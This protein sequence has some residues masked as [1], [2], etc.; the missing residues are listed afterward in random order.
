MYW[1]GH[2][3]PERDFRFSR[4]TALSHAPF[5]R[6]NVQGLEALLALLTAAMLLLMSAAARA[7]EGVPYPGG[8]LHTDDG[9]VTGFPGTVERAGKAFI[10]VN[11]PAVRIFELGK[12]GPLD[13]QVTQP[14]VK[15]EIPAS[16]TGLVFG[17][18]IDRVFPANAYVTAT[19]AYGLHIVAPDADGDGVPETLL[20]GRPEA[21]WM[22]G[23]WGPGGGP[24][25]IWKIDGATGTV[26]LLATL[27]TGPAGLGQIAF[28]PVH[29]QLFV[30]DLDTG[31][32]HRLDLNGNVL[33]AFD[34]GMVGRPAAGLEAV[35]DDGLSADITSPDFSVENPN[36]WGF[37]DV[38]RRVWGL[39]VH[40]GRLYYAVAAG[41]QVFS[42]SI[43]AMTGALGTDVRLEIAQVPG[44]M[45]VSDILFDGRGRMYLAQRGTPLNALDFS[46][47]HVAGGNKVLRYRRDPKTGAWV[48]DPP[49]GPRQ[50]A[51]GFP[52]PY[53]NAAG[54]IALSCRGL[55]WS[56]G[57]NLRN[58]PVVLP[59][60]PY[61]VHGLQGTPP[62][63]TLPRNAPPFV[64]TFVDYDEMVG[65]PRNVGH[66]G[67]IAVYRDCAGW[68][69]PPPAWT[70]PASWTPPSPKPLPVP[71]KRGLTCVKDGSDWLCDYEIR[72]INWGAEAFV[73]P[74]VIWDIPAAGVSF[75]ALLEGSIGF[76]CTQP[77]GPGTKIKC[78][79]KA[80]VTLDLFAAV[81]L[82]LRTRIPA[83]VALADAEAFRN[84]VAI[85]EDGV[86]RDCSVA[87]PK[88]PHLVP[89]KH[90]VFCEKDERG[91]YTCR[92]ILTLANSGGAPFSGRP[93]VT[94]EPGP[95][96]E[97]VGDAD[98]FGPDGVTPLPWTCTQGG[99]AGKPIVC[100]ADTEVT[101]HPGES[102]DV[103][104][105]TRIPAG[106]PAEAFRN[107]ALVTAGGI[108]S[109]VEEKPETTR[110]KELK[111]CHKDGDGQ[112][113]TFNLVF[114]NLGPGSWTGKPKMTDVPGPGVALTGNSAGWTCAQT[115]PG[116][117]IECEANAE[118][119][120]AAG[121]SSSVEVTVHI[122]GDASEAAYINCLL[123]E[124]GGTLSQC[125][126]IPKEKEPRLTPKKEA[127]SC[128]QA[129]GGMRCTYVL[130]MVN[131]GPGIFNGGVALGDL[132]GPGVTFVGNAHPGDWTCSQAGAG[133]PI[134][135]TSNAA[136]TIPA[137][138][139][140]SETIT[141]F[142]PDGSPEASYRDCLVPAFHMPF[143]SGRSCVEVPPPPPPG[144]PR[145][146]TEKTFERCTRTEAGVRCTW[147][148]TITNTGDGAYNGRLGIRDMLVMPLPGASAS[149]TALTP[150]PA[151]TCTSVGAGVAC[152]SA[153]TTLA[154]GAS[155]RVRITVT[156][157]ADAL[158]NGGEVNNCAIG[159]EQS[160]L[161]GDAPDAGHGSTEPGDIPELFKIRPVTGTAQSGASGSGNPQAGG[162]PCALIRLPQGLS[163]DCAAGRVPPKS[164]PKPSCPPGW[165]DFTGTQ[166]PTGWQTMT[167]GTG[168][169][170]RLCA[171]PR[172][173]KPGPVP[174]PVPTPGLLNPQPRPKPRC[175]QGY[176]PMTP[177]EALVRKKEGWR[178][179]KRAYHLWCGK[180]QIVHCP[181]G[182]QPV[183]SG[184]VRLLR[185][186]GWTLKR[187]ARNRWC[188]QPPRS[189]HCP[190]GW[191]RI[192]ANESPV[193]LA[194][195]G[196]TIR[197]VGQ[198]ICG[199]PPRIP[200]CPEE[201]Q[202]VPAGK[203]AV[204]K[205]RGWTL[206]RIARNR[207]CGQPPAPCPPRTVRRGGTCVPI[208]IDCKPGYRP[209]NGR[210]VPVVKPCPP[211]K[212]RVRGKCVRIV[213][214]C[215]PG[216]VRR[217]GKCVRIIIDC[218]PGYRLIRGKCVPIVRLCPP[219]KVR[220]R[221]KCVRIVK[222]CKP[223]FVRRNGRC[224]RLIR[225]CPKGTVRKGSRCVP[226][227]IRPNVPI[228]CGK[229]QIMVRGRCISRPRPRKPAP[230]EARPVRCKPGLR[231]VRGRCVRIKP[232]IQ[233]NVPRPQA[234][235]TCPKGM[236][237][238]RQ[239]C[240]P[241]RIDPHLLRQ[242]QTTPRLY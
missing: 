61:A 7:Q 79:A 205:R 51:I 18:A 181:R 108:R 102:V 151:W 167:V 196:W 13:G 11:G 89:E 77:D 29:Y 162:N 106:S 222:P 172:R 12:A 100:K 49:A 54:G 122:P 184:K 142:I 16:Q 120:L 78:T 209:V 215:K 164:R 33:D 231:L 166:P 93:H 141:V 204:L 72:V 223:G 123:L 30:S 8:L 188:G 235:R 101:I 241:A 168:K 200:L 56:S 171:R 149:A 66:V 139:S 157:P 9:V 114:T 5:R 99:G 103:E 191:Q 206:K 218:K 180:P 58:D 14:P 118:V 237:A 232:P 31:L 28:D 207:W 217:N 136:L 57:D 226:R 133:M 21:Q 65:D 242:R 94:D 88:V 92:Y 169:E 98:G 177:G 234:R 147:T 125:M 158:A 221:G 201:F 165:E 190:R 240:M 176:R 126:D 95:G 161:P 23:Q 59:F 229:G 146:K 75:D 91:D 22:E 81:W 44:G 119:T 179:F 219:G 42:V 178:V 90:R 115:A 199:K 225:P 82:K 97:L 134:E 121:A 138:S 195:N 129:D 194:E 208:A 62:R 17:V 224:V 153:S 109:C 70:P 74:L 6:R 76:S 69:T 39:A 112:T 175:P 143:A 213:K 27:P 228:R 189:R 154:P 86:A 53:E 34:H 128:E 170:R 87:F 32:I 50:Y 1:S 202:P 3:P 71:Y 186:R 47:L 210:C 19:S 40:D 211:G 73:G 239:G 233:R 43:D 174:T 135:C 110:K 67:D 116:E 104:I 163:C 160:P 216:F 187:I 60:G 203:V 64:A 24:G 113:C 127:K 155:E 45:Q 111:E 238:T 140:V 41:P 10:N 107:C 148:V 80:D 63:M 197:H 46:T 159:G 38:R 230:H 55:L 156:L 96:V 37:T 214:P 220:V 35:A 15:L 36:T 124:E 198:L 4:A 227:V 85:G 192:P 182:W 68:P 105:I 131:N 193:A 130:A 144:K 84:C 173:V 2:H 25:S 212:V 137:G 185:R 48:Q 26:S 152:R 83:A 52:R 236:V 150:P 117:A 145:L 132:V 183:A 20:K